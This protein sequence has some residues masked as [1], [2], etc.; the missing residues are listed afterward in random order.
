MA[1]YEDL[2]NKY[3]MLEKKVVALKRISKSKAN[4]NKELIASLKKRKRQ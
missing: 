2:V 4:A 3:V 1:K